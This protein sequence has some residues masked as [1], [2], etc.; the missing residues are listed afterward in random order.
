MMTPLRMAAMGFIGAT[1]LCAAT[2]CSTTYGVDIQNRTGQ[3]LMVEFMDVA[4]DGSTTT[5]STA[6][7]GPKGSF[8]NQVTHTEQGFGKRVRFSLPDRPPQDSAARVDLK[9][10]D[11]RSRYYD[12]ELNNGRLVAKELA[13][14]RNPT[15]R[16]DRT[17]QD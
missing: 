17:G 16:A 8:T 4:S 2:G 14:G 12:L 1:A 9:L 10:S 7:L 13:K 15:D 3:N 11:D 6:R 5:Y